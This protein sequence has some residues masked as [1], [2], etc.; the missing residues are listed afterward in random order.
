[1]AVVFKF[2]WNYVYILVKIKN[3]VDHNRLTQV[4]NTLFQL[5]F[6]ID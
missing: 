6:L 3:Y 1:M 2:F 4:P 5:F